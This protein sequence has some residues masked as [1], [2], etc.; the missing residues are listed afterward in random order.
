VCGSAGQCRA[1]SLELDVYPIFSANGCPGCHRM[2][3]P[4]ADLDLSSAGAAHGNLVGAGTTECGPG[5]ARVVPGSPDTSYLINKLTGVDM[6]AG[7]PM[8]R[9]R[10]PLSAAQIELI[11][12]WIA[13]GAA[14]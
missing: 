11:R 6:C 8:P 10:D 2:M 7:L 1:L 12:A 5:R 9:G 4:A 13:G 3:G 14:P